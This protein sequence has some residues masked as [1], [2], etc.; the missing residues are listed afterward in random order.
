MAALP[1]LFLPSILFAANKSTLCVLPHYAA[2]ING[3]VLL[4]SPSLASTLLSNKYFKHAS[5]DDAAA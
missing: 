5:V 1:S 4:R 3:V 2:N